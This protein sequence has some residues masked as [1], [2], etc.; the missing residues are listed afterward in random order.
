MNELEERIFKKKFGDFD[1]KKVGKIPVDVL[2]NLITELGV[3]VPKEE[4]KGLQKTWT[5]RT[6]ALS[7]SKL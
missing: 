2:E 6:R 5:P 7:L 3:F 4:M 1:T